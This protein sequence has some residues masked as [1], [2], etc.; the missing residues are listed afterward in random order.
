ME[1]NA[2][3]EMFNRSEQLHGVKYTKYI[4]DGDSKTYKGII[5]AKPYGDEIHIQKKECINHVQ[6]RM[7]AKLRNYKK[8]IKGIGGKARLTGKV[9]D[10][11]TT[12]YG[13]AIRRHDNSIEKMYYAIWATFYDNSSTNEKPQHQFCPDGEHSWCSWQKANARNTLKKYVHKKKLP[14]DVL[15]AIKPIYIDLSKTDLLERCLGGF[16]QN[17]N[18]SLNA[19]IWKIAPKILFS[20][21]EVVHAAANIATIIFNEGY[22]GL[23]Q[24]VQLMNMTI[25][26]NLHNYCKEKDAYRIYD[27]ERR[28]RHA[29]G[30]ALTSYAEDI[31]HQEAEFGSDEELFYAPGIAD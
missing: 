7:G 10:Q 20:G 13:L 6:K 22:I 12:Y 19:M 16:N 21:T 5:E 4:G 3:C 9:I 11:L 18:E 24:V 17:N 15:N 30:D 31:T 25:G 14:D 23:L 1:V 2:I 28:V 27:A 8:Q 29:A 26:P